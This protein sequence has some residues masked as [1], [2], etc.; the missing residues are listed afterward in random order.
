MADSTAALNAVRKTAKKLQSQH[1][2]M[3]STYGTL[4]EQIDS[5]EEAVGGS[6][7]KRSSSDGPS[8]KGSKK[9]KTEDSSDATGW[10]GGC[11]LVHL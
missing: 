7:L 1:E 3:L 10:S 11:S 4:C 8:D 6:S 2:V 5:L 9:L